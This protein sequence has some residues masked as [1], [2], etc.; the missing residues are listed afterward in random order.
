MRIPLRNTQ[1]ETITHYELRITSYA[2]R[3]PLHL[4]LFWQ[5]N[6]HALNNLHRQIP[7]PHG[8]DLPRPR[9]IARLNEGLRCKLTVLS[10]PAG[11]GKTT[12]LGQ[13]ARQAGIK[14]AWLSLRPD[15]NDPARFFRRLI[16]ALRTV[17]PAIGKGIFEMLRGEGRPGSPAEKPGMEQALRKLLDQAGLVLHDFAVALDDYQHIQSPPVHEIVTFLLEYQPPQMHVFVS[18]EG[19][20]PWSLAALR[21]AAQVNE[22]RAP[23]LAFSMDEA[24]ALF[25]EVM[26]LQL[27]YGEISALVSRAEAH[28]A[29]LKYTALCL[30]EERGAAADF[31]AGFEQ[32]E[33]EALPCLVEMLL[34]RQTAEMQA[35]LSKVFALELLSPAL[36]EAVSGQGN[37]A[38]LLRKLAE[39]GAF[40][41]P[42]DA[43]GE[44]FRFHPFLA[45][46]LH[47][48]F[49]N[50]AGE[51]AEAQ[52]RRAARWLAGQGFIEEAFQHGLA[53]HDADL[54]GQLIEQNAREML[55]NGELV[56]VERWLS[57]LPEAAFNARPM[58]SICRAWIAV[59]TQQY[60]GVETHLEAALAA[61]G[62]SSRP[63]EIT[64]HAEAIR[65]FLAE[66]GRGDE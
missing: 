19:D 45:T 39:T 32:D 20:P 9:L 65:G 28:P 14:I 50:I 25:N 48:Y 33:R 47:D 44:W 51:A 38:A 62:N 42:A 13:W 35:F 22:I 43:A 18:S 66:R 15:D 6:S 24:G 29:A 12:L 27:S 59:I 57:A 55:Q 37:S 16:A 2:S 30:K 64:G 7:P 61:R 34:A 54:A 52:R 10:A 36:C 11:Y 26:Q 63:E 4:N 49:R 21:T 40:L 3:F 58:L 5:M 31:I 60:E 1:Y 53:A 41:A 8:R 23:Y 56:T 46:Y 17:N